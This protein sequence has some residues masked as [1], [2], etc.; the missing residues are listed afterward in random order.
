MPRIQ[1]EDDFDQNTDSGKTKSNRWR[2]LLVATL[3]VGALLLGFMIPY[4][5]YLNHEVGERFGKLRWQVPTRVYARPL[6]VR[7]GLAMDAQ[8]LKTELEAAAYRSGDGKRSGS[9]ANDGGHWR[10]SSRGY[11]DVDGRVAP[12]VLEVVLS[13]GQVRSVR[14]VAGKRALRSARLDPA[15]IAT[16]YG[17]NQEERRLVRIEEVPELMVTGLQA[18]E[19]RDF[20]HHIGIDISG[21]LRAVFV[22]VKSGGDTRQGAST[23]TQQLARSG[24]LGIG[25]EQTYTRKF[26][27]IL[28]ALLLEARYDKKT[29]LEAYFNQVDLGQR[30]AQA[31]RG[32][33]AASEYWFGRD[34]KDLSTEQ[35]ALLIGMVKGPSWYNP[36]RNPERALE[37]R[38]FVL[39]QMHTTGL[40][41]DKEYQRALAAPLGITTNTGN[42]SANRFPAYVDLVR[43]QL[44]RDYPVEQLSGAG[45]SVMTGMAPSAQAY[46]EAA[47]TRTLD[48]LEN[49]KRPPLE[50]GVV[51]TDA[52]NGDVLAVVGSREFAEAGFNRAVDARRPVGSLLKPFVYLLALAQPDKWSLASTISDAPITIGLGRGKTWTPGNSDGRSHGTVTLMDALARSY[53]QAT[54]RLGMEVQPQRLAG[55]IRTLTG[56]ETAAQPSLILGAMDQSPFAMAQMYQ[57]LASG[58]EIQP[59][60]AVRGVLD[61]KGKALKRYD[62]QAPPAQPGDAVA[63][64]LVGSALQTVVTSGT[65][66]ALIRDGLGRL[67]PAGKTGTSNDGRDSWFAGYT[68][69]HLAIVWVGNDQNKATG[70]YGATGGMRVWANIFMRLPSAQLQLSSEGVDWRWVLD[71]QSTDPDCPGARRFP[72]VAGHAPNYQECLYVSPQEFDEFGNPIPPPEE[73]DSTTPLQRAGDA[74]RNFFGGSDTEKQTPPPTE[75][76]PPVRPT[77]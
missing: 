73:G 54:V 71:G 63:A 77:Q 36:K 69:D 45:L 3:A 50:A 64:R 23:L 17:Q 75:T 14:D 2:R 47:V 24:L 59:L 43:K 8:T 22:N 10:I 52:H 62:K 18:V 39:G 56:I 5:V 55:L 41:G 1:D 11:D 31:I 51:V 70:L 74:I 33:A 65:A 21:M 46:A 38:N 19:D 4:L 9:Y 48:A 27:E 57:F 6:V 53:N 30:G 66:N 16:L 15:R 29:I 13:G 34:L 7:M 28:Y 44:A 60:H 72:F 20:N 32:V 67:A 68:G 42:L 40:I 61:A 35:I 25:K 12:M 58:G 49:K 76:P 37:R 26:K